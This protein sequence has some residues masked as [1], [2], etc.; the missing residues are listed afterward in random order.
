MHVP[1]LLCTGSHPLGG[2]D[3][4]TVEREALASQLVFRSIFVLDTDTL[5]CKATRR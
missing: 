2:T 4:T 3:S 5:L 1:L